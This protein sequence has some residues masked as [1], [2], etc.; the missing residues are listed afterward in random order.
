[1]AKRVVRI[2]AWTASERSETATIAA[3]RTTTRGF[4]E[5]RIRLE[6]LAQGKQHGESTGRWVTVYVGVRRYSV[7]SFTDGTLV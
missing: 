7:K 5:D 4:G 3:A 1:M 6:R 2:A